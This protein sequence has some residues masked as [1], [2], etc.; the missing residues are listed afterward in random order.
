MNDEVLMVPR[1]W[2]IA[3]AT[4]HKA[5]RELEKELASRRAVIHGAIRAVQSEWDAFEREYASFASELQAPTPLRT[6]NQIRRDVA[7]QR[8]AFKRYERDVQRVRDRN[9][10]RVARLQNRKRFSH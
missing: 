6:A 8:A 10:K 4:L 1:D 5:E 3:L 2:A 7:K 9:A